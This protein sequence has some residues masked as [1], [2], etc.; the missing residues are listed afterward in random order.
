M[1]AAVTS[2][3]DAAHL[4]VRRRNYFLCAAVI[5]LSPLTHP[6]TLG[7]FI[8]QLVV[9]HGGWA[10]AFVALGLLVGTRGMR[11]TAVGAASSVV[12]LLAAT[13][14]IHFTGGLASPFFSSLY[15]VP[16]IVAVFTP[17]YRL[18]T[19]VACVMTLG[20][21]VVSGWWDGAA[22]RTVVSH[23]VAF[24]FIAGLSL[25]GSKTFRRMRDAEREADGERLK[26]LQRLAESE[27][28]RVHAERNRA[29]IER[30]AVVG[31]LAAGVAHEV[32]N[33]LAFVKSN[34]NFLQEELREPAPDVEEL[35]G[36]LEETQQGIHRIQQIV[37]DLRRFSREAADSQEA[38][39]V[40][41]ALEEAQR[42]ASVR[43]RGMGEVVRDVAPDLPPVRVSQ[44][45]LVQVLLN[46][47]LNAADA[48]AAAEPPRPARIVLRARAEGSG[49][50]LEVEDNG[51]G[52]PE[53]ALPRLFEPFFTTKPPGKGTGLG[54]ALCREY[55]AR[56]GGT[57]LA[58]NRPE[59]GA[60]FTLNLPRAEVQA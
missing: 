58:E 31:Q 29:E 30:L 27:R 9:L 59:G 15:A 39:E 10:A 60:R 21:V 23:A 54:L 47:L 51:P 50:R 36:A 34:L 45:H 8:P 3:M 40:A 7:R 42:L 26:A 48:L 49:V 32:N 18:P 19:Q 28:K 57:L 53:A 6:L 17:G 11:G 24:L 52:I 14:E 44:R 16:L 41:E 13:V 35:R 37:E 38:C 43:L 20:T 2:P 22:P 56:S 12:S 5:A 25:Y 33:P 1:P 46:L 55:L 4:R